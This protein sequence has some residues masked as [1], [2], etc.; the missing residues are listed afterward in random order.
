V[1]VKDVHDHNVHACS[2]SVGF[3]R[4]LPRLVANMLRSYS[5]VLFAVALA[6]A[7]SYLLSSVTDLDHTPVSTAQFHLQGVLQ[8]MQAF[9]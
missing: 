6:V 1:T 2:A 7:A 8:S 5:H 3:L 9:R 4:P